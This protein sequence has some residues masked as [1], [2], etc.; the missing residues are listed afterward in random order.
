M[1]RVFFAALFALSVT[2]SP[3]DRRTTG[4]ESD[5][6]GHWI[7]VEQ[8]RDETHVHRISLEAT[9]NKIAGKAGTSRLEGTSRIRW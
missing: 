2:A 4:S 8:F 7:L 3:Q 6:S 5:I 1:L 9:G